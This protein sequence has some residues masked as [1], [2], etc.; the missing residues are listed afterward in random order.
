MFGI[1]LMSTLKKHERW[2]CARVYRSYWATIKES[3]I[4]IFL[5]KN[6]IR[7]VLEIVIKCINI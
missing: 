2:N 5:I 3:K 1:Q 7:D 6:H 4:Y